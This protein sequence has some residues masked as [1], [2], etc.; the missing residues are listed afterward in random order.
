[1][2]KGEMK[3]EAFARVKYH[4]LDITDDQSVHKLKDHLQH[5][6][7]GLDVLVNNAGIAFKVEC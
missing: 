6:Y 5:E 7:G 4:Q 1:M 3:P 2:L